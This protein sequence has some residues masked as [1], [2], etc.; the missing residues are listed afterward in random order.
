VRS[1]AI[2][3]TLAALAILVIA[4]GLVPLPDRC[5]VEGL[6]E[7]ADL[8]VVHAAADGFVREY[9]PSGQAV[10]PDGPALVG[11]ANPELSSQ[12]EELQA[13]KRELEARHRQAGAQEP[14]AAQIMAEQLAALNEQLDQV[15][16]QLDSLSIHAPLSGTW[17]SPDIEHVKGAYLHRGDPVGLVASLDRMI[18]RATAGQ[19]VA[20][21]LIN[22]TRP[23]V[24]IRLKDRPDLELSG[25]ILK[26]LP[27]GQER[28]PSA[29][30]GFAAG[31]SMETAPD[32]SKGLKSAERFFEIQVKPNPDSAVR[33]LGGQRTVVRFTMPS[34]PLVVQGWR[35]LHQLVLKRFHT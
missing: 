7:P 9:L 28:L 15:N 31:G 30:L 29:A 14:G 33:L 3:S 5:R 6:V 13:R 35:A 34:R 10:T 19:D 20:A 32:D 4:I 26:I 11:A 1:R 8:A 27:A 25:T 23:A 17:V 21:M 2:G 16:Q 18:V 22:E 12:R 24:E